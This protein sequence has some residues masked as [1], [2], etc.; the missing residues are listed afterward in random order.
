MRRFAVAILALVAVSALSFAAKDPADYTV[1]VI[2]LE[3]HWTSHNIP[4]NEFRATGRGNVWEGDLIRAFDFQYD[5]HVG[6]KRTARNQPYF[7]KWKKPQ[8]RLM[9]LAQKI[10][11]EAKYQECELETTVHDGVYMVGNTGLTEVPQADFK[12]WRKQ[13]EAAR[14]LVGP[15]AG[16]R[17]KVSVGSTPAGAEIE[18]DGEFVGDTPS[19]L[20]LT[21]GAHSIALT[22]PGYKQWEKKITLAPGEIKLNADLERDRILPGQQ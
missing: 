8:L 17:S 15:A 14:A 1:K 10:G 21:P 18:V 3:Q 13:R 7:G 22:K 9:V 2:I 20:E 6:L 11:S 16:A 4:H 19:T 5:C 12:E